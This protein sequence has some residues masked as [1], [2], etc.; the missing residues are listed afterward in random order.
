MPFLHVE[1]S[2]E[3]QRAAKVEAARAGLTL[4]EWIDWLILTVTAGLPMRLKEPKL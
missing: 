3:A 4:K 2:E 1:I